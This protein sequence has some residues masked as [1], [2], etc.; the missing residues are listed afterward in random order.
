MKCNQKIL[1][2]LSHFSQDN[3]AL[4]G[5]VA[6]NFSIIPSLTTKRIFH[7]TFYNCSEFFQILRWHF[8]ANNLNDNPFVKIKNLVSFAIVTITPISFNLLCYLLTISRARERVCHPNQCKAQEL[9]SSWKF[10][11]E[12]LL[13]EVIY[14]LAKLPAEPVYFGVIYIKC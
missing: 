1:C 14:S 12:H 9:K 6:L 11:Q 7:C 8:K 10:K 4:R 13:L 2:C 5:I 3:K